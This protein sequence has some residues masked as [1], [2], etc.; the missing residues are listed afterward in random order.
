ME[1]LPDVSSKSLLRLAVA[2]V[3]RGS[4]IST[5]QFKGYDGLVSYGFRHQRIDKTTR[6]A[7]ARVYLNGIEG[8]WSFAKE[9][10]AKFHGVGK[11]NFILYLKELGFRYNHRENLD[12]A[13]YEALRSGAK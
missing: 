10:L 8:F 2:N 6:F 9:R 5:D 1:I 11:D 3:K 4:L 12:D 7:N 13:I